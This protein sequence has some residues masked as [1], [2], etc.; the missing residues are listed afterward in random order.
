[1]QVEDVKDIL[2]TEEE[3]DPDYMEVTEYIMSP[4]ASEEDEGSESI[5]ISPGESQGEDNGENGGG[6][7]HRQLPALHCP[8]KGHRC[9][10]FVIQNRT[11]KPMRYRGVQRNSGNGYSF[12][13]PTSDRTETRAASFTSGYLRSAKIAALY[14]WGNDA[15]ERV[16][17]YM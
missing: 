14:Q 1:M 2:L 9:V 10:S 11:N 17:I 7:H 15:R 12:P 8:C 16:A 6:S 13:P 4:D 3:E 5:M